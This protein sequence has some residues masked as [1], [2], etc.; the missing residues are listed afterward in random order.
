MA[1]E[2]TVSFVS[3]TK[4]LESLGLDPWLS[5]SPNAI[6]APRYGDSS[7]VELLVE[8]CRLNLS[9]LMAPSCPLVC[10]SKKRMSRCKSLHIIPAEYE[11][12][13]ATVLLS[14]ARRQVN[15]QS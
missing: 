11:R 7:Q 6:A 2:L 15:A 9:F 10:S 3:A 5:V 1:C 13:R 12:V 4:P 8:S 14:P